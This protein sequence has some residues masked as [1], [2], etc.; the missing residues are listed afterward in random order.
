MIL[1]ALDTSTLTGSVA[2]VRSDGAGANVV[3]AS[4]DDAVS[5]HSDILLP[6]V[7]RALATAGV[8][9]AD[10]D[11]IA[12][13]CGPGSF[14]GL[15]IGMA[16]AKGLAFAIGAP[17]WAVSSLAALAQDA[18]HLAG[19]R[20]IVPAIDARRQEVF[21]GFYRATDGVVS[22]TASERVIAPADL[23]RELSS[24][25]GAGVALVGDGAIEYA[26]ALAPLAVVEG[27]RPTPSAIA[28]ATLALATPQTDVLGTGAP[29]YI[30]KAEAE[31]RFPDGNPGGTFSKSS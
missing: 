18:A 13:G 26:D 6:L 25:L 4:E 2:V 20:L 5:T 27:A 24:A 15:R 19:D 31:I 23:A 30:R 12:V 3:L 22:A 11:A 17:L 16:T 7:E 1:L 10:L 9:T 21:A 8:A 28:V 29:V 14:T